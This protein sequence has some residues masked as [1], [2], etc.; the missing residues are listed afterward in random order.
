MRSK[1][2]SALTLSF[3]CVALTRARAAVPIST[4]TTPAGVTIVHPTEGQRLPPISQVFVFGAVTPGSSL[5]L[6]GMPVTPHPKGGYLTMVPLKPGDMLL[7][8][9]TQGPAGD[10]AKIERRFTVASPFTPSPMDPLTLEKGSITPSDNLWLSAGDTVR[11]TFQGSSGAEAEFQISG[12]KK[13]IPMLEI[14]SSSTTRRGIYEGFYQ[15]QADDDLENENIEVTLKRGKTTLH[16]KAAGR[17]STDTS[18]VTRV[19]VITEDT[20][21]ARTGPEA[22]Y[23]LFLYKGMR[24]RLSGKMGASWRVRF[25]SIQSGWVKESAILELPRGSAV[26]QTLLT[27]MATVHQGEST[28][29]RI[30]LGDVVPYRSE[31]STDPMQL[32][33]TLFGTVNKTD[34]I[35]YD[36]RDPLVRIV[37]WKQ[38]APD[39]AQVIIEPTFKQWWGYDVR[40]E[41]TTLIVEVRKPWLSESIKGMVIAVDPGHGGT[42][43]GAMGPHELLEKD[44]NLAIAKVV[45]DALEKEG[46]KPFL[47]REKDI[48]VSLYE[49][50]RIAWSR[51]ARL[52]VSI[53]CNASGVSENPIWNNGF[54]IYWYQPQSLPLARALHGAYLKR[55][56][57]PDHGLYY[58]DLAVCRMTQMP[59]VL[60]EQAFII[61][62]E[63]EQLIFNPAFQK[64]IA[65]SIVEGIEKFVNR[66]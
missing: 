21:A 6:N 55:T 57:L 64:K 16:Q 30:P 8:A 54:S 20:V 35:K 23:D 59:A 18:G 66:P 10:T 56:G 50:P 28:L 46:A 15:L 36:P 39:T 4:S 29:V 48:E 5:T 11:V 22:G 31:Q 62:P 52:F 49:R 25:S 17:L 26:P 7:T 37:R 33:I 32:V 2:L 41:G 38:I 19:G 3:L 65:A 34:L 27:N 60:T 13:K 63:Q 43:K 58:A 12:V 44:A 53:H 42:D 47:V 51:N 14:G 9:E 45:V 24:V 61:V 40:Y 1:R